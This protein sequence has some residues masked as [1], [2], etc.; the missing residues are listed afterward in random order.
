MNQI[1]LRHTARKIWIFSDSSVSSLRA[2]ANELD[3]S[4]SVTERTYSII[5]RVDDVYDGR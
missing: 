2:V 5:K 4:P 1:P 3:P